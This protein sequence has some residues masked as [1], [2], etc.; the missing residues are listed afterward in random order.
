MTNFTIEE[1][2]L[3]IRELTEYDPP[4]FHTLIAV[5][6]RTLRP[7]VTKWCREDKRL[8]GR[9]LE[10]DVMQETLLRLI[11]KCI[12]GFF[13]RTDEINYDP[14]GFRNWMFEVAL[15]IKR[16]FALRQSRRDLRER[17][18]DEGEEENIPDER[19][20]NDAVTERLAAAFG[21]ILD[22]DVKIYKIL[23]WLAQCAFV[24]E[25][26]VARKD[27][28][29]MLAEQFADKTLY[30]LRDTVYEFA[31]RIPWMNFTPEHK[32]KI[33]EALSEEYREGMTY[34]QSKY[35]DFFMKKDAKATISDWINRMNGYIKRNT[36]Q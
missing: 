16:D 10:D 21:L 8:A 24:I 18:F 3:I 29:G 26:G 30:E 23:T 34:G 11:Q 32:R 12:T 14:E 25:Y 9:Q 7:S 15:N 1:F 2:D 35:R 20:D 33:E 27:S 31:G 13:Y 36:E 28:N 4:S 6:D 19:S 5:A 22:S 17:C